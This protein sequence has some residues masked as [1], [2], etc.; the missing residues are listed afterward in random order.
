MKESRRGKIGRESERERERERGREAGRERNRESRGTDRNRGG[1]R[2][3]GE[4]EIPAIRLAVCPADRRAG[5][6]EVAHLHAHI[7]IHVRLYISY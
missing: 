4:K 5:A 3:E 7:V 6:L 1:R 2:V